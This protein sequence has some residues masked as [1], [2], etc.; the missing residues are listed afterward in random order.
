MATARPQSSRAYAPS[1]H[2]IRLKSGQLLHKISQ[3]TA[4]SLIYAGTAAQP[5][6]LRGQFGLRRNLLLD[7][8]DRRTHSADR[9]GSIGAGRRLYADDA[10]H[11]ARGVVQRQ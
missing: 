9:G 11:V 6:E 4:E 7:F 8:A 1:A 3:R 2:S 5:K 10:D